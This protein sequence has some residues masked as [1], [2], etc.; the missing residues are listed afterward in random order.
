MFRNEFGQ[1]VFHD[2]GE[3]NRAALRTIIFEVLLSLV[4]KLG[5]GKSLLIW[6]S[7]RGPAPKAEPDHSPRDLQGDV[8]GGREVRRRRLPVHHH[9]PAAAVRG[10]G[11]GSLHAQDHRG[12]LRGGPPAPA[13]DGA[14]PPVRARRQ[15]HDRRSDEPGPEGG[16]RAVRHREQRLS[17]RHHRPGQ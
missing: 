4:G 8:V 13:A 9:G 5:K 2:N 12:H 17:A 16:P 11:D 15:A 1:G 14:A 3:L 7:G 6:Y 10:R